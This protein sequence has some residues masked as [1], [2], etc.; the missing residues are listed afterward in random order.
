MNRSTF[1]NKLKESME[2]YYNEI[3]IKKKFIATSNEFDPM[4]IEP[5]EYLLHMI[6]YSECENL[7]YMSKWDDLIS[8]AKEIYHQSI[9][10]LDLVDKFSEELKR[11]HNEAI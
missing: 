10:T 5:E 7:F 9:A 11:K 3:V 2:F 4:P 1:E 8:H 6:K